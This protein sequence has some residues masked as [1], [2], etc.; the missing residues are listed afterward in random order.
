MFGPLSCEIFKKSTILSFLS[1]Y[2]TQQ[3]SAVAD[4][5]FGGELE[6]GGHLLD[7]GQSSNLRSDVA[8]EHTRKF[9]TDISSVATRTTSTTTLSTLATLV[10]VVVVTRML[11]RLTCI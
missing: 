2:S 9:S 4:N 7:K 10:G 11:E 3:L 8:G 6:V 1:D 5:Q